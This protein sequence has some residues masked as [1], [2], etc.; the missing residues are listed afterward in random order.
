[1]AAKIN[2]EQGT[3]TVAL[4]T[5]GMG[6]WLVPEVSWKEWSLKRGLSKDVAS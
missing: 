3:N 6:E 2:E 1:M 5:V 4:L